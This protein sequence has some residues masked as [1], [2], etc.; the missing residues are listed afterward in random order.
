MNADTFQ[1]DIHNYKARSAPTGLSDIKCFGTAGLGLDLTAEAWPTLMQT[2]ASG[3]KDRL[4]GA[5]NRPDCL[6]VD[7]IRR[8]SNN[9]LIQHPVHLLVLGDLNFAQH[10]AWLDRIKLA[11]SPP[12]LLFEL[13][14]E[15]QLFSETGPVAKSQVIK[16]EEAKY[17]TTCR[18]INA[19]QVGGVLDRRW[20]VVV[21]YRSE[22]VEPELR[23]PNLGLEISRP[24]NNCLRPSGIPYMAYRK[25]K[26][27]TKDIPTDSG[28]I[29]HSERDPMPAC[30]GRVIE[31]PKG[32]RRLL[33]DE[34]ARGQGTPKSWLGAAYPRFES[35][36]KTVPVHILEYLSALL[37]SEDGHIRYKAA[38]TRED[39]PECAEE[40]VHPPFKWKLLE[41]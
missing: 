7:D 2:F 9:F 28:T 33:N 39:Q 23:W 34:L 1:C 26:D 32:R 12:Q 30:P 8:L 35:V 16:W 38:R 6:Q 5:P 27:E 37:V 21:H 22:Q 15:D 13:W 10:E 20:L 14:T 17:H 29:P 19:T 4:L 11:Q 25:G 3:G 41:E 18:L 24:M 31:T 36:R 40:E